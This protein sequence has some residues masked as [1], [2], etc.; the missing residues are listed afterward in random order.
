MKKLNLRLVLNKESL[1]LL[2]PRDLSSPA[3]GY[4]TTTKTIHC[5][6]PPCNTQPTCF[7]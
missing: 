2:D 3:G 7:C 5:S 1:R 6:V 4:T